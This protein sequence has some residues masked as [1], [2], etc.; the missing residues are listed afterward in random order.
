MAR[1]SDLRIQLQTDPR[2]QE[3]ISRAVR[4][5]VLGLPMKVAS[6]PDVFQGKLWACSD[7]RRRKSKRQKDLADIYRLIE[8]H[9]HLKQKLPKSMK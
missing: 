6:L 3:F 8:G 5:K 4:K 9:P 2:Y 1:K 7:E